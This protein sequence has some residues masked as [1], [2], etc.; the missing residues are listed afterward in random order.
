MSI[1]CSRGTPPNTINSD[2]R[3]L[4]RAAFPDAR[5]KATGKTCYTAISPLS[6]DVP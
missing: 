6:L 2:K 1:V 3:V 4:D 5:L